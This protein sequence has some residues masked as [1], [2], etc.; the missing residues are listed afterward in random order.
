[1]TKIWNVLEDGTLQVSLSSFDS[2]TN[3]RKI[4][5]T[6]TEVHLDASGRRIRFVKQGTALEQDQPQSTSTFPFV[7]ARIVFEPL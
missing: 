5:F 2:A 6:A 1:M 3:N 7:R 4:D